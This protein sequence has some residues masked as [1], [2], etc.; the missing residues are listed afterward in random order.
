MNKEMGSLKNKIILIYPPG[1]LYQRG[2]DRCQISIEDLTT[3][4]IRACNDLGYCAAVLEKK[5]YEVFF[6]DYQTEKKSFS[7]VHQDICRFQPDLIMISVTNTTIFDDIAFA[8]SLHSL[9]DAVIV[10][11]GAIFY[12]PPQ[13]LFNSLDLK[14]I[15]YLIGG[16]AETCIEGTADYSLRNNGGKYND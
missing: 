11:K 14:N 8:D 3:N 9:C 15:D 7:D 1:K 10:Q 5:N 6:M 4:G 16:E 13:K 2:G 12:A